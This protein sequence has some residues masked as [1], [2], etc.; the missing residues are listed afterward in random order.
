MPQ[1]CLVFLDVLDFTI[2]VGCV[3]L[4]DLPFVHEYDFGFINAYQ[5]KEFQDVLKSTINCLIAIPS[6]WNYVNSFKTIEKFPTGPH[7]PSSGY[8]RFAPG[9]VISFEPSFFHF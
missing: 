8:N 6:F 5:A 7:P 2:F 3:F 4:G 1:D 9:S